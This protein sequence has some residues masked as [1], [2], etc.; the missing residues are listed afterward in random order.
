MFRSHRARRT[1]SYTGR[2]LV[3]RFNGFEP[4]AVPFDE[5]LAFLEAL[6]DLYRFADVRDADIDQ[7]PVPSLRRIRA[8]SPVDL[9]WV[10]EAARDSPVTVAAVA[11]AIQQLAKV[12]NEVLDG[13]ARRKLIASQTAATDRRSQAEVAKIEAETRAATEES[14]TRIARIKA[15]TRAIEATHRIAMDVNAAHALTK[16]PL[17]VEDPAQLLPEPSFRAGQL[18]DDTR[19]AL[20]VLEQSP[21]EVDI[22]TIRWARRRRRT[23]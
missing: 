13:R 6:F 10:F 1:S 14:R 7:P 20:A 21:I 19:R 8:G 3:V 23:R 18:S 5:F 16:L 12:L 22:V 9:E 11:V 2:D 15:E 4:G 17:I